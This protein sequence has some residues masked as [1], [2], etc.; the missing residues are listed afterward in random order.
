[1]YEMD[2]RRNYYVPVNQSF[3]ATIIH[4]KLVNRMDTLFYY[5]MF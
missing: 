2:Q 3:G 1:M 4:N 5:V